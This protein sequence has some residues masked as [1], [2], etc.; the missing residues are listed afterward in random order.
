[1]GADPGKKL[2]KNTVL[3]LSINQS[4]HYHMTPVAVQQDR[5]M[6]GIQTPN[7][8]RA[9][10]CRSAQEQKRA[11]S[12]LRTFANNKVYTEPHARVGP[13]TVQPK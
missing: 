2:L 1:M 9:V 10:Q 7:K 3:G 8:P 12:R 13:G 5:Q 11:H 6:L 4:S